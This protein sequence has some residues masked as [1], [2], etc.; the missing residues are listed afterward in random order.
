M[1]EDRSD[2]TPFILLGTR[3]HLLKVKYKSIYLDVGDIPFSDDV[4]CLGVVLDNELKF[5]AHI[6][7]LAV[8]CFYHI[9]QMHSVRR[10]LSVDAANTSVNTFIN[11]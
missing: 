4:T 11:L 8:K 1:T 5:F 2:C 7:R 6:K 9:H 10:L 3:Q